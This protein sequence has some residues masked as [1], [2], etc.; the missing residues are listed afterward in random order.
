MAAS[1]IVKAYFE[2]NGCQMFS[3]KNHPFR[4]FLSNE[5]HVRKLP[6]LNAPVRLVQVLICLPPEKMEDERVRLLAQLDLDQAGYPDR[7]FLNLCVGDYQIIWERHT[8]IM[9]YMFIKSGNLDSP[10]NADAIR[11]LPKRPFGKS[12]AGVVARLCV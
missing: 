7:N 10:F 4:T 11:C 3:F 12:L 9:S 8:E 5:M 2:G 6:P 1:T